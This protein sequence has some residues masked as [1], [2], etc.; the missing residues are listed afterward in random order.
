MK[1]YAVLTAIIL[2]MPLH[3]PSMAQERHTT[4]IIGIGNSSCGSWTSWRSSTD[5]ESFSMAFGARSWVA[6][7]LTATAGEYEQINKAIHQV[8]STGLEAWIDNWCRANP[9]RSI[10][11]AANALAFHLNKKNSN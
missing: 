5:M 9:L 3:T 8:D 11:E 10:G 2:A 1:Q 7:Y 4:G 6:G